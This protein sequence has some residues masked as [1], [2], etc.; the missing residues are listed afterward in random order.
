[1]KKKFD[2]LKIFPEEICDEILS[3]L[4]VQDIKEASLVTKQWYNIIGRSKTCMNKLCLKPKE[5]HQNHEF[6]KS[7]LDSTRMYQNMEMVDRYNKVMNNTK[8]LRMMRE[9]VTKLAPM[10][11]SLKL[12]NDLIIKVDIPRLKELEFVAYNYSSLIAANGLLTKTKR[13]EKL[14]VNCGYIDQKSMKYLRNY[15]LE[16][17]SIKVLKIED[18][19]LFH[20]LNSSN[21]KFRLDE[22]ITDFR[23]PI[24]FE[25]IKVHSD[26]LKITKSTF[27]RDSITFFMTNFS[28]LHTLTIKGFWHRNDPFDIPFNTTI[29]KLKLDVYAFAIENGYLGITIIELIKKVRNLEEIEIDFINTQILRALINCRSLKT[30][31]FRE[32]NL[33]RQ[34]RD[35]MQIHE[36]IEFVMY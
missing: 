19:R 10:L 1:M 27:G 23:Q 2:P 6:F 21:V 34:D 13:L 30:V 18:N 20:G 5:S 15:L 29:R 26:S 8:Y 12:S 22:F 33:T 16:N 35:E 4:N 25:F 31:K 11:V 28:Q 14:T 17:D 9:V 36:N 3:Y 32:G 24:P 7:I